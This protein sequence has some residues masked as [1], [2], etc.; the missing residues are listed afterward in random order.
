MYFRL[1]INTEN[2]AF[3]PDP[4]QELIRILRHI[5]NDLAVGRTYDM[6]QTIFDASGNDVGRYALKGE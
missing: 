1:T 4:T 3:Q 2:D 6:Y 5:A